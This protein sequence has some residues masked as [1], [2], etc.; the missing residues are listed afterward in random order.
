M[1]FRRTLLGL[2]IAIAAFSPLSAPA[3]GVAGQAPSSGAQ[4]VT[5]TNQVRRVNAEN[6]ELVSGETIIITASTH[7]HPKNAI[8]ENAR[9]TVT[10]TRGSGGIIDADDIT[11]VGP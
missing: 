8:L 5:V 2:V 3:N 1:F 9:V 10:G 4:T 6:L 11:V 7:L